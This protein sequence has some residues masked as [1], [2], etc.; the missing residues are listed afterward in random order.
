MGL[1]SA[2]W[3]SP[4]HWLALLRGSA[5]NMIDAARE[6]ALVTEIGLSGAALVL[7]VGIY[8]MSRRTV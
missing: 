1:P 6:S 8:L 5:G 7:M 4:R 2:G 3:Y